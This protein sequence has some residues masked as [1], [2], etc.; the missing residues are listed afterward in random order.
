VCVCVCVRVCV[1]MCVCVCVCVCACLCVCVCVHTR[2]ACICACVAV[3]LCVRVRVGGLRQ[4]QTERERGSGPCGGRDSSR[5]T[6]WVYLYVCGHECESTHSD[7]KH[8]CVVLSYSHTILHKNQHSHTRACTHTHT[9]VIYS[10]NECYYVIL[11]ENIFFPFLL[12]FFIRMMRL[13][14]WLTPGHDGTINCNDVQKD[15]PNNSWANW[16]RM[17]CL[18]TRAR[19]QSE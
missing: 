12:W 8:L 14:K 9:H 19:W 10:L 2:R 4:E 13:R 11:L 16:F 1:C 6:K 3:C 7:D 15:Y 17:M 18:C 5:E